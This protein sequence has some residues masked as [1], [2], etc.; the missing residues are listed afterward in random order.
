MPALYLTIWAALCLFTAGEV[1]RARHPH[2][3]GLPWSASA[4]GLTLAIV[5]TLLAFGLVHGWSHDDA[6][7]KTAMQ[8]ERVF[9]TAVGWGVYVNYVFFAVWFIDLAWWRHD[10]GI[11]RRGRAVVV[12]LQACYLVIIVNAAI[13]FAAGDRRAAGIALVLVLVG[14]WVTPTRMWA[15]TG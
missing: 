8:T 13:V 15:R 1:G 4:L 5:H 9:G 12:A 7:L 10:G 6:V 11:Q 2:R 3:L 14:A